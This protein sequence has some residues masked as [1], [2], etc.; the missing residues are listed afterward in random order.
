MVSPWHNREEQRHRPWFWHADDIVSLPN[1][2]GNDLAF[3]IERVFFGF[4]ALGLVLLM[5]MRFSRL[6]PF[7]SPGLRHKVKFISPQEFAIGGDVVQ[8]V[9]GICC[10][11][12]GVILVCSMLLAILCR[13]TRISEVLFDPVSLHK[14]DVIAGTIFAFATSGA[15]DWVWE[16]S[17]W[18]TYVMMVLPT[19]FVA[20]AALELA[21]DLV[22]TMPWILRRLRILKAASG[23]V[24]ADMIPTRRVVRE[25]RPG[26][27]RGTESYHRNVLG[28]S[29]DATRGDIKDAYEARMTK[30]S[31]EKYQHADE[32]TRRAAEDYRKELQR[33]HDWLL[34]RPGAA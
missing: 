1:A 9:L 20:S 30:Y 26:V 3:L 6:H 15:V 14:R 27:D 24:P 29:G 4:L 28:V 19:A 13:L 8:T 25:A 10:I 34:G 22:P 5:Y 16:G 12:I 11:F 17:Y 21:Y 2:I 7:L 31:P 18:R 23:Y 33:A 32:E